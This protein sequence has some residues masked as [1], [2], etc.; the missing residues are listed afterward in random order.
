MDTETEN[1]TVHFKWKAT[2]SGTLTVTSQTANKNIVLESNSASI[3]SDYWTLTNVKEGDVVYII[4]YL[5]DVESL[6]FT[7]HFE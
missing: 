3:V 5:E 4:V 1:E 6:S 2:A 7:A